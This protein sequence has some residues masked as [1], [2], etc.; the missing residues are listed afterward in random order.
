MKDNL[1]LID[2][3]ADKLTFWT[4]FFAKCY[5]NGYDEN[6]DIELSEFIRNKYNLS[7]NWV[8]EFTKYYDGVLDE[9]D[10]YVEN[11]R[12][13]SVR[14]KNDNQLEIEFHPGDTVFYLNKEN[15][16][17]TGPHF[18]IHKISLA[19]LK[20]LVLD[21][22]YTEEKFFLLLPMVFVEENEIEEMTSIISQYLVK[23]PF[24]EED[25]EIITMCIINDIKK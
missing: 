8:D 9:E 6:Q 14:L 4:F 7:L 23:L 5:P 13:L 22:D 12:K 3:N 2:L 10:G 24:K 21:S 19:K 25:L 1:T 17:C 16:G 20:D 15:I 11:P 18:Y